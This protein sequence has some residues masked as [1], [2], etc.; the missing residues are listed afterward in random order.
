MRKESVRI[1]ALPSL[2]F[3]IFLVARV[4]VDHVIVAGFVSTL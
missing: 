3:S 1:S 2:Q 4:H